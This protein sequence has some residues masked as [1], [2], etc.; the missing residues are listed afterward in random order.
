[1]S[2]LGTARKVAAAVGRR[3]AN[4]HQM[5]RRWKREGVYEVRYCQRCGFKESR[6][7]RPRTRRRAPRRGRG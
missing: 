6:W 2:I 1:M 4:G 5:P 3:C 7:A